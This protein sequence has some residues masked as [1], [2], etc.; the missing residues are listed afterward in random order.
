MRSVHENDSQKICD[1][2][3]SILFGMTR[4]DLDWRSPVPGLVQ[5]EKSISL[6]GQIG[7]GST[8]GDLNEGGKMTADLSTIRKSK[9]MRLVV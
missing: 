3:V 4:P 6:K 1:D 2:H 7:L 8:S 9:I 5:D